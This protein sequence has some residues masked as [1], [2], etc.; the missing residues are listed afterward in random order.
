MGAVFI[1]LSEQ[2]NL[3]FS[4]QITA[5]DQPTNLTILICQWGKCSH[6][7]D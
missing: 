5:S 1:P 3:S 6:K 4:K 2:S 7:I